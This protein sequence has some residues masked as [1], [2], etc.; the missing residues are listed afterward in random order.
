M[1]RKITITNVHLDLGAGRRGTDMGSSAMHVAGVV[2]ALEKLGHKVVGIHNLG[3]ISQEAA[4]VG[5][6]HLR[7]LGVISE[8]CH[9][10]ADRVEH[11]LDIGEFPLLLGGDHSQAIGSVAGVSR[12]LKRQG[13]SLGVLWVDAHTDMNTPETSPSG[14]IHGMPLAVLLGHGPEELTGICGD[15]PA[16]NPEHVVIFGVRSVDRDEARLVKQTGVRVFTMSEIDARGAGAC[17]EEA[18]G[19]L[20]RASGGIHLSY[21]L[22]G[23]DPSVAPGTGTP[24]PGGLNFRESHLVCETIAR[25]KRLLSMEVVELNPILDIENRTGKFA[26]WLIQSA[27][28]R[29]ILWN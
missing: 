15:G 20:N 28:G 5:D 24:V 25:S 11:S 12:H 3:Q 17:M 4:A 2:P 18:M 19:I 14:N 29:T 7:Y 22:D 21:D 23:S 26:V 8:V 6:P 1:T 13:K 10:L 27:L 16:L 9:E